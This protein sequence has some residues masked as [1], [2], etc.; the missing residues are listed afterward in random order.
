MCWL[1]NPS[2]HGD[3]LQNTF[4]TPERWQQIEQLFHAAL[5]RDLTHRNSFLASACGTDEE[6]RREV[7]SLIYFHNDTAS[8]IETPAGDVAA[9]ILDSDK[10]RLKPGHEI[11]NYRIIRQ[12]GSG[13]MGEVYLADDT[14]L[15]R[16][17]ALKL[18]PPQF[19][20]DI[21]R[22]RRFE[23][24]SRAASALNHPNIVTIYEIGN[25]G[26]TRFIATEFVDGVT[27]RERLTAGDMTLHELLDVAAQVAAALA[28]AHEAGIV[29]R[30]IKPD[31]IML[32]HD[33]FVK[34]LDFGL[35]KLT[36]SRTEIAKAEAFNTNPGILMGTVQYMSPEQARGET[37][38]CRTDIWS[39]GVVLYEMLTNRL[40]FDG[41]TPSHSTV[42]ILEK[43][44]PPLSRFVE[45]P[46]E[47]ELIVTK[48]LSKRREE[49]YQTAIELATE[50]KTLMQELEVEAHLKRIKHPNDSGK[51]TWTSPATTLPN[52]QPRQTNSGKYIL[53]KVKLQR[54]PA[55]LAMVALLAGT[56]SIGIYFY[57]RKT[58]PVADDKSISS[59]AVI[60][61]VNASNDPGVEY[62][63][64]G[65]SESLINAL[66]QI[67]ELKV[68]ARSSS[69]K[70]KG[71]EFD[72]KE[73][74]KAL[75][76]EAIL[77]GRVVQ[78]SDKLVVNV[79]LINAQDATQLW[80]EQY[81]RKASDLLVVQDEISYKILEALRLHLTPVEQERLAKP[82][83]ANLEAYELVLK[84]RFYRSKGT[85]ENQKKA[86]EFFKQ[87]IA[88]DPDYALAHAELSLGYAGLVNANV[89][90][91]KEFLPKAEA[92]A[93][94]AMAL[95]ETLVEAHLAL[96]LIKTNAWEWV[97]AERELKRAIEL[98]PNLAAAHR[99]YTFFLM[100]Q[101]RY[102][103]AAAEAKR[104]RELDPLWTGNNNVTVYGLVLAGQNDEALKA[105]KKMLE[106]S[107]AD[108]YVHVLIGQV[109]TSKDQ[110]RE[111]LSEF[112]EA[113]RLGDDS[114]DLQVYLGAAYARAGMAKK[115]RSMLRELESGKPP[116]SPVALAIVY[117]ALGE[118]E[119]AFALL[120]RGYAAHDQQL[121]WLG[122]EDG[123]KPLRD[124]P[125][126]DDLM[127]RVG[128][129]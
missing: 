52:I 79:E 32:R 95:D 113:L 25:S 18:L 29:H 8:F 45:A 44:P 104:V 117:S 49:R 21:D 4:M 108:P 39:L 100:I 60:P 55:L 30:D 23:Q 124:D 11:N 94:K 36:N 16:K 121:I 93:H 5:A 128:V 88:I 77:T 59:I 89:L 122:L 40:P 87:A 110:H 62:L 81:N 13:G 71:K 99:N 73:V 115:A 65:L 17:I 78:H 1:R 105:A 85:T 120:E 116:L 107:S 66:S 86:I 28:A 61:F 7:E 50:L 3:A 12:L 98:N 111:A 57:L 22:V 97:D 15:H 64:D 118:K 19:T 82:Q 106:F 38:D 126:F 83:T 27:L 46:A 2:S 31:N 101:G 26:T 96:A 91:Q 34:V 67:P 14:K 70:Y 76:V 10:F 63:S 69:F 103:E 72:Q 125:R 43:D 56:L 127:R 9:A 92:A 37:I 20:V 6:L 123:F 74:A 114:P 80:G 24:E 54:T 58:P 48:T 129:S 51:L 90:N 112:Q 75:G 68:T 109:Y 41:E 42:S 47:L 119:Q 35:A 53:G 102:E 84:G 33:G